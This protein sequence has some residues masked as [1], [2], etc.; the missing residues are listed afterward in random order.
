MS[1]MNKTIIHFQ[2]RN[3]N[4]KEKNQQMDESSKQ[5]WTLTTIKLI[6]AQN[7]YQY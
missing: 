2:K 7:K 3:I 1:S 4:A 6:I 5:I